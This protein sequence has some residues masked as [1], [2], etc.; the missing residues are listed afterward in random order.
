MKLF[1]QFILVISGFIFMQCEEV[2]GLKLDTI[3]PK[4]VVDASIDWEK[5]TAGN[6]QTIMLTTTTGYYDNEVPIVSG[7]TV[8]VTTSSKTFTFAEVPGTGQYVCTDFEPVTGEKYALAISYNGQNYTASETLVSTPELARIDQINDA[9]FDG[10]EI[11][12]KYYFLD[13]RSK[14]DFY[15][16]SV[17]AP[18]IKFP[19]YTIDSD[20]RSQGNEM[21]L[22]FGDETTVKGNEVA[23]HLYGISSSYYSYMRR[24]L[25]ATAADDNG[26]FPTIP[27]RVRGN[28]VNQTNKDDYALGYFRVS[29]VA[30]TKY[31]VQ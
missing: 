16:G 21:Y 29:E 5:G 6:T 11:E 9:G 13:D 4:L 22:M 15:M 7:A 25:E 27:P 12:I 19:M 23:I 8:V 31:T 18:F 14:D 3:P 2:I 24:L 1:K 20:E 30:T 28:I 26:P 10:D 17:N